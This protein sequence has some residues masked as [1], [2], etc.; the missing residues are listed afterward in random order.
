MKKNN[1]AEKAIL[2]ADKIAKALKEGTEKNL[3]SLIN[4]AISK[5]VKESDDE[6]E[7][8][9]EDVDTDD[10]SVKDE[11]PETDDAAEKDTVDS[12]SEEG[13]EDAD[14]DTESDDEGDDESDDAEDWSDEDAFKVSDND[15]DMRKANGDEVLKMFNKLDDDDQLFIT[16]D[17]NGDYTVNVDEPGEY[18]IKLD[19]D[20]D[21]D[22]DTDEDT[23]DIVSDNDFDD[24]SDDDFGF[25]SEDIDSLP[26]DD[27]DSF[28]DGDEDGDEEIELD[29]DDDSDEEDD[30]DSLNEDLGYTDNYQKD[31]F[32]KKFNMNEPAN[33]Q[34]TYGM[35]NG[36]PDGSSKP[37][38]G[39]GNMKPFE[40][41]VDE[42]FDE[43][44]DN[45][46][47]NGEDC[48][49][50]ENGSGFNTLHAMKKN[51]A[52]R[53]GKGR[54]TTVRCKSEDGDYKGTE[55]YEAYKK[56]VAENKYLKE[57]MTKMVKAAKAAMAE[58]KQYMGAIDKMK[59]SMRNIATLC[60]NEGRIINLLVNETTTKDER[61]SIVERYNSVKTLQEGK[62]LYDEFK[63]QLNEV[64]SSTPSVEK[65]FVAESTNK[66]NETTF[67]ASKNDPSL[68]LMERMENISKFYKK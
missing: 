23:F 21:A 20:A 30:E 66:L 19:A 4:E 68:S 52:N 31:V 17:D 25:D 22:A 55:L 10:N 15:F 32:S 35:D 36:A 44:G 5:V 8:D 40:K 45:Y 1:T 53:T 11:A 2:E 67:Y 65:Q 18:V 58:N 26:A 29:L 50:E 62:A 3:Q 48:N 9:V 12:D 34:S 64:K 59:G 47:C 16:K 27:T 39:K 43:C 63:R 37:W 49:L 46:N 28:E 61:K 56:A 14:V 60:V 13:E 51:G 54:Q 38:A 57:S 41:Q 33:K 42:G 6:D 24:E 7:F